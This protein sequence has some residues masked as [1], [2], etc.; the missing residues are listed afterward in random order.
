MIELFE[1]NQKME[2]R[3]SSKGNQLKWQSD[4]NIWYK[5]DYMGYEGLS[6][7]VVSHLLL[8]SSLKN[9]EYVIYDTEEI[10]YK[11][12]QYRGCRSESFLPEGWKIITLERLFQ[13]QYGKSL[14]QCI[15]SI[16][17]TS[18]RIQFLVEQTERMTGLA[19]VGGYMAKLFTV[20]VLFLNEDRHTHNIAVL[21]DA[22]EQYHYCPIF[23]NGGSLLADTTQDYPMGVELAKLIPSVKPASVCQDFDELLDAVEELYGQQIKFHFT[24]NDVE[25]IL[26]QESVY[27]EEEKQR[28]LEI[29]AKQQRKYSYLFRE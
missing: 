3:Q 18:K 24:R 28:V 29:M 12:Q 13:M 10:H 1:N 16:R 19:D 25:K 2:S 14:H 7:Y 23:D 15:Y 4:E 20:D 9:D 5:A 22:E 21:L 17:D 8:M 11:F 26:K 6:E 27:S